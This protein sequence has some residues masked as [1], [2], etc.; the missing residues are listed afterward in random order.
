MIYLKFTFSVGSIPKRN[1]NDTIKTSRIESEE[2]IVDSV[3]WSCVY[4]KRAIND[5]LDP[6]ELFTGQA[7]QRERGRTNQRVVMTSVAAIITNENSYQ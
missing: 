1:L 3:L 2:K 6:K 5:L 7:D 4:V